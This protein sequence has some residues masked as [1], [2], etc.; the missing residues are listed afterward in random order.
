[1]AVS[2]NEK[3]AKLDQKGSFGGHVTFKQKRATD[4]MLSWDTP[5]SWSYDFE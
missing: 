2:N 5:V 4:K 1:M 3:N